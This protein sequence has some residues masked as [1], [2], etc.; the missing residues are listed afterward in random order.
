MQYVDVRRYFCVIVA[1]VGIAAAVV[2]SGACPRASSMDVIIW[3]P[4]W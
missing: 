1:V 3:Y 4:F 2:V